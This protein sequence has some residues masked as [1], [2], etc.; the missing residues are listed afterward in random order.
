M[1]SIE[2]VTALLLLYSESS[3]IE[4]SLLIAWPV[5]D[6]TSIIQKFI[7]NYYQGLDSEKVLFSIMSY[8]YSIFEFYPPKIRWIWHKTPYVSI[9]FAVNSQ[10]KVDVIFS[11]HD[12][13]QNSDYV[14]QFLPEWSIKISILWKVVSLDGLNIYTCSMEHLSFASQIQFLDK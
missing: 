11:E 10:H 3:G 2:Y 4:Y 9:E 7:C 5:S 1:Y 6:N 13:V 8:L 14:L 12:F